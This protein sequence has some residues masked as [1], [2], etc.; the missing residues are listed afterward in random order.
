MWDRLSSI[1]ARYRELSEE[2]ATPEV[3]GDYER[4][5]K[6]AR[7]HAQL[8]EIVRIGE[9]YRK[10]NDSLS[11]ARAIVEEGGDAEFVELA[12][13]EIDENEATIADLEKRLRRLL[14]PKGPYDDKDVIVEIRAAAGGDE[15]GLFAGDLFRMYSR[16]AERQKWAV[17]VLDSHQSDVGGFKEIVF[18]V[19]GSGAYSRLKYESGV[20]RVQRVPETEAQGRIHTSTSTVAVLPEADDVDVKIDDKDL[21]FDFFNAGGAG[22]QNVQKNDN[23]VRITHLPTGIVATC[24][25]E[26]SQLKNK[27]KAMA[28]LRARLLDIEQRKQREEIESSRRS[29]VGSGD[30]AE[31]IRTYNYPQDRMTDHR[32]NYTRHNL[33]YLLDGDMDDVIDALQEAEQAELLEASLA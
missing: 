31:K 16:Y 19:R 12:R 4:L 8:Q 17:E 7:E 9:E 3:T 2:M 25:D 29:Q 32:V 23:A 11:Q 26:R 14:I 22:G 20:H 13:A 6:L 27:T 33:P 5:Q 21:R 15:A 28:V 18:E 30:R 1:E 10:A 24:Q